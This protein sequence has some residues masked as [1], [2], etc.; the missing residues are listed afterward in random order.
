MEALAQSAVGCSPPAFKGQDQSLYCLRTLKGISYSNQ[1]NNSCTTS[2]C[3]S[4]CLTNSLFHRFAYDP[5]VDIGVR[6]QSLPALL[7]HAQ[8]SS[9]RKVDLCGN[10]GCGQC[11][12]GTP[13]QAGFGAGRDGSVKRVRKGRRK[14]IGAPPAS[15]RYAQRLL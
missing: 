2:V 12:Y 13:R 5:V 15:K 9:T 1:C 14:K 6:R 3:P 7:P 8:A 4:V 11:T 10:L